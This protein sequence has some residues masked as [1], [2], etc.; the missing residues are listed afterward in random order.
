MRLYILQ[1]KSCL[2]HAHRETFNN[3][4]I[5]SI[6]HGFTSRRCPSLIII[7]N[8]SAANDNQ[9]Q[10]QQPDWYKALEQTAEVDEEIAAL[11]QEAKRNPDQV[12]Q[13]MK[14]E[15]D[16]LY[17]KIASDNGND[18]FSSLSS[19]SS[20]GPAPMSINVRRPADPQNLWIW[21]EFWAL[22]SPDETDILQEVLNSWYVVGKLGGFNSGN[23]QIM[24]EG[25]F[26]LSGKYDQDIGTNL[27]SV[28]HEMTQLETKELWG[29]FCVDLGSADEL[30]IDVLINMLLVF[31]KEHV[32]LRSLCVG[33]VN[34]DW[35]VGGGGFGSGND[36][37]GG[38]KATMSPMRGPVRLNDE[39]EE[40]DDDVDVDYER[41]EEI[42]VI[43]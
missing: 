27:P 25:L 38:E 39:G 33:G 19:S 1:P 35:G 3:R 24:D 29:R 22:P 8:A 40:W 4:P 10:E 5:H 30:G 31:S 41:D 18:P 23:T 13:R 16:D 26:S 11:L 37:Y 12:R 21:I 6:K 14:Q 43:G 32:G 2:A 15:M 7:C 28:M 34:D 20:M 36:E 42:N 9:Q 17:G